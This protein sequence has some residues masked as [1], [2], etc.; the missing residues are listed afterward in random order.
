[1]GIRRDIGASGS[2]FPITVGA[3]SGTVGS[4]TTAT[5]STAEA[6]TTIVV[7]VAMSNSIPTNWTSTAVAW[8]GAT[9]AGAS[10]FTVRS[11]QTSSA[12][13]YRVS[14]W[15]ANCTQT[16]SSQAVVVTVGATSTAACISVSVDALVGAMD[17]G[18]LTS[19]TFWASAAI[20]TTT[21]SP[22]ILGSWIYVAAG[23]ESA[24]PLVNNGLT[25]VHINLSEATGP[26]NAAIGSVEPAPGTPVSAGWTPSQ[27]FGAIAA[28]E[29]LADLEY[30]ATDSASAGDR[31]AAYAS[32]GPQATA[33]QPN[34]F[35]ENAFNIEGGS[36]GPTSPTGTQQDTA[37]ASDILDAL[38]NPDFGP[39]S[40]SA[41]ASDAFGVTRTANV[42]Q[43]DTALAS[44][45]EGV[46]RTANVGQTDTAR[47]S[48][49]VDVARAANVAQTDTALA[50]DVVGVTR[51]ANVAQTDTALASDAV[52]VGLAVI[53]TQTD[54]AL[55]RDSEDV[56]I[57]AGAAIQVTQADSAL[58]SDAQDVTRTANVAQTDTALASDSEA[59]TRTANV[60]QTDTA[61]ASDAMDVAV[62]AA[63]ALLGTFSD[64]V[65]ASDA[66]A[67]AIVK[68]V[69]QSDSAV[70]LDSW[71][72]ALGSLS[73]TGTQQDTARASDSMDGHVFTGGGGA[74]TYRFW[75]WNGAT[76]V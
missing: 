18:G 51:T 68:N 64:A 40:D 22:P 21:I 14:I 12:G 73:A 43:S 19:G 47:A 13:N 63:G 62:A 39:Q 65:L 10:T 71:G 17:T 23:T 49:A 9:P 45:A 72:V 6:A 54:T 35:Q 44:D 61:L 34:V 26:T 55:A 57:G 70:A 36:S 52:G 33:F 11:T 20:P 50:S 32:I 56:A 58:A 41:L 76:W 15:T 8:S 16:L 38:V 59:V 60:A 27:G 24:T 4:Q 3:N 37:L 25:R 66:E 5:F 69:A 48:D 29:I 53:L 2:V 74:L 28:L 67:L 30:A 1:M 42:A 75:V 46:A 7:S 31:F